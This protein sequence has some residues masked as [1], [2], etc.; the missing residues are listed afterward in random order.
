MLLLQS[1]SINRT[2]QWAAMG[3]Q[4]R[5]PGCWKYTCFHSSMPMVILFY[6]FI[7][8]FFFLRMQ[9]LLFSSYTNLMAFLATNPCV[10]P[11]RHSYWLPLSPSSFL[12]TQT[13]TWMFPHTHWTKLLGWER[14]LGR[15]GTSDAFNWMYWKSYILAKANS[16]KQ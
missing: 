7:L 10:K 6:S 8:V 5:H 16:C 3:S 14:I 13:H 11:L 1:L 12:F 15:L 4:L 2:F 9:P